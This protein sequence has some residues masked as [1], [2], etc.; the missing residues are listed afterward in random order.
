[1]FFLLLRL[2]LCCPGTIVPAGHLW[3]K[4]E[5]RL[6]PSAKLLLAGDLR[7]GSFSPTSL[8]CFAVSTVFKFLVA[9]PLSHITLQFL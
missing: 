2:F 6:V 4:A 3:A 5:I 1:M 8:D 9:L 7:R